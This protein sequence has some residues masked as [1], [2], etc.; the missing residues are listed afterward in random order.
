MPAAT[1]QLINPQ[2]GERKETWTDEEGNFTFTGIQPGNYRLSLS[3]VGFRP[4]VREPIPV[5]PDKVLK[6][7]LAMV[8][9]M[10]EG[11]TPRQGHGEVNSPLQRRNGNLAALPAG[12]RNRGQYTAG[13]ENS[14]GEGAGGEEG[15]IRIAENGG[16]E[17]AAAGE[18]TPENPDTSTSAANSFLLGG[19]VG[20]VATPGE[21]RG[22]RRGMRGGGMGFGGGP[23][24]QF[25]GGPG[26]PFGGGPGGG[27]RRRWRRVWWRAVAASGE[28]VVEGA[29]EPAAGVAIAPR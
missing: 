14:S 9:A 19:G 5:T 20:E 25:G 17:N 6:I 8:L 18:S 10:P 1:V 4:D 27:R 13:L 3:L 28:E 21:G 12:A 23:G 16:T 2:T 24:G 26:S 15:V 29:G 11:A 22:G 7:N